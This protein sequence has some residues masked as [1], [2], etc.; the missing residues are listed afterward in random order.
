MFE[1]APVVVSVAVLG[2]G[3]PTPL[4]TRCGFQTPSACEG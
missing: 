2:G 4:G 3:D 1:K